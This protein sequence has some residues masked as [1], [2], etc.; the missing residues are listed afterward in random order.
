MNGSEKNN[1][2]MATP[3]LLAKGGVLS[4][5]DWSGLKNSTAR[6]VLREIESSR[7]II[8]GYSLSY[9]LECAI[10]S[11]WMFSKKNSKDMKIIKPVMK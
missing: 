2:I 1:F 7:I 6:T 11:Y 4:I 9:P 5:G 8:E 3:T 10:W